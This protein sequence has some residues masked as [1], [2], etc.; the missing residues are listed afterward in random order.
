MPRRTRPGAARSED[1]AHEGPRAARC[2]RVRAAR[3]CSNTGKRAIRWP[4]Y[5]KFLTA[6][7]LW[8]AAKKAEI[9]ARIE[10]ELESELQIAEEAPLPAPEEAAQGVYCEGCHT[11]EAEWQRE[12]A[13]VTP[14]AASVAAAWKVERLRCSYRAGAFCGGACAGSSAAPVAQPHQRGNNRHS[15][16]R[17][18]SQHAEISIGRRNMQL[19]MESL[20]VRRNRGT[21]TPASPSTITRTG[22]RTVTNTVQGGS[23]PPQK[24]AKQPALVGL[25][26][27]VEEE[28]FEPVVPTE[29]VSR[30]PF[31]RGPKDKAF[32]QEQQARRKLA[33]PSPQTREATLTPMAE[34]TMLEAIR[35]AM[36]EEMERDPTVVTL[37]EDIGVYGG[38]FK[39]TEGLLAKFGRSA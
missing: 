20:R 33:R 36:F 13:E 3:K 27:D 16:V 6:N 29:P 12:K 31:G 21:R 25:P 35:Q 37:G 5:E 9:D 1:H 22:I 32:R 15:N 2:R 23:L 11:M 38:A 7:N 19:S 39:A 8:D 4:Q 28:V 14:P 10:S 26:K 18:T 30:V 17:L 24:F 34:V